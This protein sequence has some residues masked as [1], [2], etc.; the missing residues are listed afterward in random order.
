MSHPTKQEVL[1]IVGQDPRGNPG[2]DLREG[3]PV[4]PAV[5]RVMGKRPEPWELGKGVKPI[6]KGFGPGEKGSGQAGTRHGPGRSRGRG[7]CPAGA[8]TSTGAGEAQQPASRLGSSFCQR[9]LQLFRAQPPRPLPPPT[10]PPSYTGQRPPPPP[11]PLSALAPAPPRFPAPLRRC[12]CSAQPRA[13][14][15]IPHPARGPAKHR[16]EESQDPTQPAPARTV[17]SRSAVSGQT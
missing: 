9:L 6:L 16:S 10:P 4:L 3:Q 11:P 8:V 1:Q 5:T 7:G 15:C 13:L 14:H 12:P 17:S 2:A